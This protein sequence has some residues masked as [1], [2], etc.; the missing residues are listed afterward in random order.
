[1]LCVTQ[2]ELQVQA[3]ADQSDHLCQVLPSDIWQNVDHCLPCRTLM[4]NYSFEQVY[5]IFED[6]IILLSVEHSECLTCN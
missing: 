4:I 5:A 3:G 1:M 6:I 2:Q